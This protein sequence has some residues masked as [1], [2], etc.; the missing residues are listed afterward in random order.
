MVNGGAKRSWNTRRAVRYL[1][2]I[3]NP[4]GARLAGCIT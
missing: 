2:E 4:S 1:N 3:E